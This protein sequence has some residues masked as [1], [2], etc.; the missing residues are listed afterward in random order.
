MK[1]IIFIIILN[2]FALLP[3]NIVNGQINNDISIMF[4]FVS[5]NSD[6]EDYTWSDFIN[7][8]PSFG[9]NVNQFNNYSTYGTPS[10][11]SPGQF[12]IPLSFGV[13]LGLK[14][15]P[16]NKK[17]W[18]NCSHR[19]RITIE[20]TFFYE[21]NMEYTKE[22]GISTDNNPV[23]F[24]D[25]YEVNMNG[26][27][28]HGAY[29]IH[30]FTNYF[31]KKSKIR[32]WYGLSIIQGLAFNTI[33]LLHKEGHFEKMENKNGTINY[34]TLLNSPINYNWTSQKETR[35]LNGFTI[36]LGIEMVFGKR[37]KIHLGSE[38]SFGNVWMIHFG[39]KAISSSYF[40]GGMKFRFDF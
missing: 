1:K 26:T 23:V 13:E 4:N 3:T 17:F 37:R 24:R 8:F 11:V 10:T 29:G 39:K 31:G 33:D 21:N 30:H 14:F 7:D 20:N 34:F 6:Y 36:P 19:T 25:Y 38:S 32:L 28:V 40:S 2:S 27:F 12:F 15:K 35:W 18:N 9:L 5:M 16:T 22:V